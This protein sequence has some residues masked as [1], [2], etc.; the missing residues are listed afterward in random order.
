MTQQAAVAALTAEQRIEA[1]LLR[2][3]ENVAKHTIQRTAGWEPGDPCFRV[4]LREA[5]AE[6]MAVVREAEAALRERAAKAADKERRWV[7]NRAVNI[8]AA[9]RALE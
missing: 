6:I 7:S 4:D 8:A 1:A 9:I 5:Q 3:A 2:V